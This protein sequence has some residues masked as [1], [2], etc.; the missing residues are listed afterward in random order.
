MPYAMRLSG[1]CGLGA[2]ILAAALFCLSGKLIVRGFDRIPH[3][4]PH[5]YSQLGEMACQCQVHLLLFTAPN[6][7]C[8]LCS[9]IG[10]VLDFTP[11]TGGCIVAGKTALGGLGQWLVVCFASLE[12]FGA[13]CMTLIGK[14]LCCC[15]CCVTLQGVSRW[16]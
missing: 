16:M 2:L 5:S 14:M 9:A 15:A 3:G 10:L 12:F 1:W 13:S 6:M 8:A 4:K 11:V 7:Y